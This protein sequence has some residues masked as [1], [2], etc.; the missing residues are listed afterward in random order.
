MRKPFDLILTS[1][2]PRQLCILLDPPEL[3]GIK[4][5]ERSAVTIR[6]AR[7]LME[8]AGAITAENG[9]D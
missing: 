5:T 3:K 8:A 1:R 9:N 7:I 6:L 4:A 2:P